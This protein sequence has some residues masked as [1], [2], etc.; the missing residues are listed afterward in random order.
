MSR[1][2]LLPAL[3]V[4]GAL[5]M[6]GCSV[7]VPSPSHS[8]SE[9]ETIHASTESTLAADGTAKD[10]LAYFSR[11]VSLV[12][13]TTD[14]HSGRA[15]VDGLVAAGF[16]KTKMQ[17]TSDTS[18]VGNPA[19]SFQFSVLWGTDCLIGQVGPSTGEPHVAVVPAIASGT[20]LIGETVTLD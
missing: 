14:L 20:C 4:I 12:W 13:Q 1:R 8:E 18:T 7:H 17:L 6:T 9:S 10:N 11:A 19:E 2:R 15:Y 3:L 5:G 16:D